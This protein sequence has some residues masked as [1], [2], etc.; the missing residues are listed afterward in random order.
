MHFVTT[1]GTAS[2]SAMTCSESSRPNIDGAVISL[3]PADSLARAAHQLAHRLRPPDCQYTIWAAFLSTWH[4]RPSHSLASAQLRYI[5]IALTSTPHFLQPP[6][7][8]LTQFAPREAHRRVLL[9]MM[10]AHSK[11]GRWPLQAAPSVLGQGERL[12][13]TGRYGH[14]WPFRRLVPL[15]SACRGSFDRL[16]LRDFD[17]SCSLLWDLL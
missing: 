4:G 7:L 1:T 12:R 3:R 17:D 13:D 5:S 14:L 8:L 15:E 11:L 10:F 16:R 2:L 9:E 6:H